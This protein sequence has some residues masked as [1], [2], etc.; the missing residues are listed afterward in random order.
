MN[1][2]NNNQC[3]ICADRG[4]CFYCGRSDKY[5]EVNILNRIEQYEKEKEDTADTQSKNEVSF[6]KD[7]ARIDAKGN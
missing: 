5:A 7:A 2:A 1:Y 3:D 6:G 4:P